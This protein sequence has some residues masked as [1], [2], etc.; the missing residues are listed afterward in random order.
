[1]KPGVVFTLSGLLLLAACQHNRYTPSG[2]SQAAP[3]T[4]S[5]FYGAEGYNLASMDLDFSWE[6]IPSCSNRPPAF[7]VGDVPED[8]KTLVFQLH[9]KS[10]PRELHGGAMVDYKGRNKIRPSGHSYKGP[11]PTGGGPQEFK[12]VVT[13]LDEYGE[14]LAKGEMTRAFPEN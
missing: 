12:W 8:T 11:C 7:T 3:G 4:V 5:H 9:N 6:G 2:Q 1:M 10:K 13:A 14:A